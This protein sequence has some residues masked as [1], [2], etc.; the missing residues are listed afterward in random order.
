MEDKNDLIVQFIK[1]SE[2]EYKKI[3]NSGEYFNI[4]NELSI[5]TNE[6]KHSSIIKSLINPNGFHGCGDFFY[7]SFLEE[8]IDKKED[9]GWLNDTNNI[10]IHTEYFIANRDHKRE[11]DLQIKHYGRIDL[12]IENLK[13][14]K[15]IIIENKI[16]A[17]D[18]PQ[19]LKR[20]ADFATKRY[21]EI[22]KDFWLFYLT[23]D[24][25]KSPESQSYEGV[26]LE[27]IHCI[28]YKNEIL[29]WLKYCLNFH[30]NEPN[31]QPL[32]NNVQEIVKQYINII[33]QL[34]KQ[35]RYFNF[36]TELLREKYPSLNESDI[37]I[38]RDEL[39]NLFFKHLE[40]KL[41]SL[42]PNESIVFV[43]KI[44]HKINFDEALK[45]LHHV[46]NI[47]IRIGKIEDDYFYIEVKD[48]S[49]LIYGKFAP[50]R[51]AESSK[52]LESEGF[53]YKPWWLLKEFDITNSS[54]VKFPFYDDNLN[55]TFMTKY[56][57]IAKIFSEKVVEAFNKIKRQ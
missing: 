24:E 36:D 53:T 18:Q 20:Y 35:P 14:K 10:R 2:E 25:D 51:N 54:N 55:Y 40:K 1:D 27:N 7:Q 15:A 31:A 21:G 39:R 45:P 22:N 6:V 12:L 13:Q 11:T 29:N 41:Q 43:R 33:K 16:Y 52:I 28:S 56:E 44:I 9:L 37:I 8:I 48:W 3:Y 38:K 46:R 30:Y 32:N 19:Q 42:L 17:K 23:L 50:N 34:T 47:G 26:H 49:A 57:T 5:T 4:F